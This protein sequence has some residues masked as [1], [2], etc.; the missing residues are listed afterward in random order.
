MAKETFAYPET[1][2]L[3]ALLDEASR[4]SGVSRGQAFEDFLEMSVCALSGGQMESQYLATVEKHT[5]GNP[6][7][8]GCDSLARMFGEMV[9]QMESEPSE[10]IKDPLGD[11][12]QSAITYGE[13][14]QFLTPMPVCRMTAKMTMA[15]IELPADRRIK[16]ND[17][18]CGSGRMLLAAA[19]IHR[20]AAFYAQDVDARCVKMTTINL[21]LRGLFGYVVH[22]NTLTLETHKVYQTG[23]DGVGFVREVSIEPRPIS[24]EVSTTVEP[25]HGITVEPYDDDNNPAVQLDLF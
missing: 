19:E 24:K 4:R 23:F 3:L 25:K 16:I 6:G 14:G 2:K 10:E 20:D 5:Q 13:A 18:C 21:A 15:N 8:R 1:K 12:F 9:S 7:Q 22:G 11:L 17:P